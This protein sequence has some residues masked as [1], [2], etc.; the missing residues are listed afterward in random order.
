MSSSLHP[1]YERAA[2]ERRWDAPLAALFPVLRRRAYDL[3]VQAQK[4]DEVPWAWVI[5]PHGALVALRIRSDFRKELRIARGERPDTADAKLRWEREIETFLKHF[6]CERWQRVD[7]PESRGVA[8]RFIQL[9]SN[10][11]AVGLSRC[12]DCGRE[13]TSTPILSPMRC[14]DC[15][16]ARRGSPQR[17]LELV[18]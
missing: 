14:P 10:E 8:A 12:A 1:A 17:H 2:E 15:V 13:T 16:R 6:G 11:H 7:E 9:Y 3:A 4:G 18:R 5:L